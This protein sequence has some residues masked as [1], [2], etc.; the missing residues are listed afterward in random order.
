MGISKNPAQSANTGSSFRSQDPAAMKSAHKYYVVS[1]D[2]I[3]MIADQANPVRSPPHLIKR[4]V[5]LPGHGCYFL[6]RQHHLIPMRARTLAIAHP[7]HLAVADVDRLAVANEQAQMSVLL[8][9][10][11]THAGLLRQEAYRIATIGSV[12]A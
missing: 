8:A 2:L 11:C 7:R 4:Q 9:A 12:Y 6:G 10:S 5:A 1:D 3:V